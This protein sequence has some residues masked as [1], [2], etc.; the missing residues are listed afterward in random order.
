MTDVYL[1]TSNFDCQEPVF[2]F[3]MHGP[4]YC[5]GG[6]T[7]ELCVADSDLETHSV[8]KPEKK[9]TWDLLC[10]TYIRREFGVISAKAQGDFQS[11]T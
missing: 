11:H 6:G 2:T 7:V 3:P 9:V 10:S 1:G 8:L 4:F 5:A